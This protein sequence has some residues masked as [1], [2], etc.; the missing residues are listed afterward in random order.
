LTSADVLLEIEE[1]AMAQMQKVLAKYFR[2]FSDVEPRLLSG[3]AYQ[4]LLRF[5]ELEKIDLVVMA[6]HG[7]SELSQVLLGSVAERIVRH[8]PAPVLTVRP[9]ILRR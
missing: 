2:G 3:T 9:G 8:S 5:I 1:D 7:R 4:A 6:T